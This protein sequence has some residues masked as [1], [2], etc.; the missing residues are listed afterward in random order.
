MKSS[1]IILP[2]LISLASAR[3]EESYVR[4]QDDDSNGM[5]AVTMMDQENVVTFHF[6]KVQIKINRIHYK[7]IKTPVLI[8]A[9]NGEMIACNVVRRNEHTL[10]MVHL[11]SEELP[12]AYEV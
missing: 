9:K 6:N 5:R 3:L 11:E 8:K 1:F 4:V 7:R 10:R 2:A 12:K